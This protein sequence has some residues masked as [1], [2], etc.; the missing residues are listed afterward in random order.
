MLWLCKIPTTNVYTKALFCNYLTRFYA[1]FVYITLLYRK[2][3]IVDHLWEN[4]CKI[5]KQ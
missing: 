3:S 2:L 4:S 5:R 1:D